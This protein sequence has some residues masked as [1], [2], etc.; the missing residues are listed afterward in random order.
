MTSKSTVSDQLETKN[1]GL[2]KKTICGLEKNDIS[3][4]LKNELTCEGKYWINNTCETASK[5]LKLNKH[6]NLIG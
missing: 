3:T 2:H 1:L 4:Q 6:L 5:N